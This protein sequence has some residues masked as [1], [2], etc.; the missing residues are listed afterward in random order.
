MA[1]TIPL[2]QGQV[3]LVDDEDYRWLTAMGP[4]CAHKD[5]NT[6][7]ARRRNGQ[8]TDNM[9]RVIM[10]QNDPKVQVDH[11]D[12]NG[13]NNQRHN[14][15]VATNTQNQYNTGKQ[16]N[17]TSGYKGVCWHKGA[18]RW[19]AEIQTASGR[20][21]YLGLFDDVLD[22]AAAHDAAA[23]ELHGEFAGSNR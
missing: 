11:E 9:H 14:L 16:R 17:N 1:K 6:Y 2:T 5:G 21:V 3:A 18:G 8:R 20:R 12:R 19:Q 23:I 10:E 22:A 15:R 7:Y 13:L 4:W